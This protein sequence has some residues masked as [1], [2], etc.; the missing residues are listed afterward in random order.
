MCLAEPYVGCRLSSGVVTW[1]QCSTSNQ[2]AVLKQPH[3]VTTVLNAF[4][5]FPIL[6]DSGYI[7]S[8]YDMHPIFLYY[9]ALWRLSYPSH[10][11]LNPKPQTCNSLSVLQTSFPLID[12]PACSLTNQPIDKIYNRTSHIH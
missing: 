4:S 10:L 9:T 1:Q 8:Q 6:E 5:W 2:R 3:H 12:L 7:Y 11:Y